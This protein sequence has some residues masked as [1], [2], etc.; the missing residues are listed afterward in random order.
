MKTTEIAIPEY[1][2]SFSR[3]TL[4]GKEYLIRFTYNAFGDFWVFG[5][6]TAQKEPIFQGIKIVPQL[7]LNVFTGWKDGAFGAVTKLDRIGRE[8]FQNGKAVFVYISE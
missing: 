5:L 3:L 4:S 2:D 8:D 6:Y 1:N 7:P